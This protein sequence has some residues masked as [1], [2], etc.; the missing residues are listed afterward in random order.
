MKYNVKQFYIGD[1]NLTID[2]TDR[3]WLKDEMENRML[4][5]KEEATAEKFRSLCKFMSKHNENVSEMMDRF[6][7]SYLAAVYPMR[8]R[9][10][11]QGKTF[12][13]KTYKK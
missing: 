8:L 4:I 5:R 2:E 12:C 10:L 3:K 1:F 11:A 9:D 6:G 13:A 7:D